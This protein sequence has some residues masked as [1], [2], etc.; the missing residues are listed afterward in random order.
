MLEKFV[1]LSR[2][3]ASWDASAGDGCHPVTGGWR[4]LVQRSKFVSYEKYI[5]HTN[6]GPY[7]ELGFIFKPLLFQ[8][9]LSALSEQFKSSLQ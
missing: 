1:R 3:L 6:L 7:S 9:N 8:S 5:D 4:S 2:F